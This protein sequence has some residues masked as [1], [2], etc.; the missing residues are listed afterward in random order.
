[1]RPPALPAFLRIA[2]TI[3][4]TYQ[5]LRHRPKIR[6]T[7]GMELGLKFR[8][9]LIPPTQLHNFYNECVSI[10]RIHE[11]PTIRDIRDGVIARL[12]LHRGY[13]TGIKSNLPNV[14]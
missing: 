6:T 14:S 10:R 9:D 12:V 1:M 5:I 3:T 7:L 11:Q 4:N 8:L 2:A 13:L